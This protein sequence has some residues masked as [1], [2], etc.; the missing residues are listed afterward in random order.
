MQLS[1]KRKNILLLTVDALRFD[2]IGCYNH[3]MNTPNIDFL[4]K[5]GLRFYSAIAQGCG[6]STSFTSIHTSTY[7]KPHTQKLQEGTQTLAKVL[8]E[9]EYTTAAFHSNPWLSRAFNFHIGFDH[10][11]D[12]ISP[13][14]ENSLQRVT[15]CI[16]SWF[17]SIESRDARPYFLRLFKILGLLF[18]SPPYKRAEKINKHV[19]E[20][21]NHHSSENFFLWIHYMDP[22]RP[23]LPP[24]SPL[25]SYETAKLNSY[26]DTPKKLTLKKVRKLKKLY[27]SEVTY[28]DFHIG[29]LLRKLE[30]HDAL[31]DSLIFLLADHGEEFMEHGAL[32]HYGPPYEELIKIPLIVYGLEERKGE[33]VENLV[34]QIDI[35]P[36]ILDLLKIEA[37]RTFRG[38]SFRPYLE[39]KEK[40]ELISGALTQQINDRENRLRMRAYRTQRWKLIENMGGETELYDLERDPKEHRDLSSER[41]QVVKDLK[42]KIKSTLRKSVEKKMLERIKG[43]REKIH[44]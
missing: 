37:P 21:L 11:Y 28:V 36:T 12:S 34:R 41:S 7:R 17:R 16:K 40:E 15:R 9:H 5:N 29:K 22:H 8:R 18:G 3:D 31:E 38:K 42:K 10:F 32:S 2:H 39:G 33:K 23:Y 19:F 24:I 14:S 27:E 35:A 20:W 13:S 6:T 44:S 1:D 26:V 4:G 25:S 43:I 30:E